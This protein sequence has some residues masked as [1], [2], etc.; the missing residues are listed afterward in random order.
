M[1]KITENAVLKQGDKT[2]QPIESEDIIYWIDKLL[3]RL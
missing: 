1:K 3:K 2:Y